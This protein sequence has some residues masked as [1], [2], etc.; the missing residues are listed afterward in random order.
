[1]LFRS[2]IYVKTSLTSAGVL[3]DAQNWQ[4]LTCDVTRNASSKP[5]QFLDYTFYLD[6]I[7]QFDTFNLKIV[8]QSQTPWDPPIIDNYR[9]VVLAS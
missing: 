8:M 5:G 3:H 6:D 1:M 7:T 2:D 9:A 4:K